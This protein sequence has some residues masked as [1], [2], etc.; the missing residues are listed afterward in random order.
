KRADFQFQPNSFLQSEKRKTVSLQTISPLIK[1]DRA[2]FFKKELFCFFQRAQSTRDFCNCITG[3]LSAQ[4]GKFFSDSIIGQ[5]V[6]FH[7]IALFMFKSNLSYIVAS[8]RKPFLQLFKSLS[9]AFRKGKL[10]SDC[11]FHSKECIVFLN[12]KQFFEEQQFLPGLKAGVSLL[13]IR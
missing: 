8:S 1:M 9:L 6:Q 13:S 4:L 5:V 7:S 12:F 10:N 2:P 11:S 3:H